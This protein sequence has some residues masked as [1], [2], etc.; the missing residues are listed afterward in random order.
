MDNKTIS[1][2][3]L[4][5]MV[6]GE[7]AGDSEIRINSFSSMEQAAQGEISF[8]T[9]V[10]EPVF[11][12]MTNASALLVPMAVEEADLPI[13]RVKD[14]YLASAII[15]NFFLKRDFVAAGIH[16]R[17]HVG[18]GC[19]I[20]EE[21]TIKANASIG[22][23]VKIGARTLI[24]PGVV[25]GDN[26][27]IGEDCEIRGNV[28]VE[29]GCVL[30]D[31][32]ILHAGTVIGSD[33]FGYAANEIGCHVKRPQVGIVVVGDDV[34]IGANCCVDRAT[35][36]VTEI[37][38]GAKLDNMVQVGHN[39]VV[40]ENSILV[41]QVGVAGSVTL[42]RNVVLGGQA[43]LSGHITLE[44]GVMVAAKG[45]VHTDLPKGSVVGGTPAMPVKQWGKS[46]AVYAKLPEMRKE[47]RALKKEL[48]ALKKIEE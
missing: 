20:H 13:V 40:G 9:K 22:D 5:A 41:S 28:T 21:I 8:V 16:D 15:H 33:G 38:T 7:I 47:I 1:L 6:N 29:E 35:F 31:R 30:G 44:D 18:E 10:K 26:V 12:E 43:G 46:A 3:E 24:H 25:I 14:P 45:G 39:V 11:S 17:A 4:A 42:G 27:T 19:E 2:S 37:K 48:A 34:E 36:G 23:N 32:V